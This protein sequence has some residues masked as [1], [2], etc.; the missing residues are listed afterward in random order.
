FVVAILVLAVAGSFLPRTLS[1]H[2]AREL[3]VAPAVLWP[4]IEDPVAWSR[5]NVW[6]GAN[7]TPPEVTLDPSTGVATWKGGEHGEGEVRITE[8]VSERLLRYELHI[9][10]EPVRSGP[11][12]GELSLEP[13]DDGS[14]TRVRFSLEIEGPALT[15]S[16]FLVPLFERALEKRIGDALDLLGQVATPAETGD[17]PEPAN[18]SPPG[19]PEPSPAE[20]GAIDPIDAAPSE[21]GR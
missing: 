18:E 2:V 9:G 8:R 14:G 11:Y 7:E 15:L 21:A 1:V 19:A 10:A 16:R 17:E 12:P 13:F 6:G 3:P 20:S 4:L 5:W